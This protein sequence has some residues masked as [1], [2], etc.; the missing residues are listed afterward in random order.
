[1]GV[2][3]PAGQVPAGHSAPGNENVEI[4]GRGTRGPGEGPVLLLR[5]KEAVLVL[6]ASQKVS[7]AAGLVN[8][9]YFLASK[10]QVAGLGEAASRAAFCFSS[11]SWDLKV[12]TFQGLNSAPSSTMLCEQ[13][14]F[15]P[16]YACV[17]KG[18]C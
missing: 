8:G 18:I 6:R 17:L 7:A 14:Y 1:M 4:P 10:L 2:Q 5:Q 15:Y 12:L 13:G 11:Y 3:L 9:G 16:S